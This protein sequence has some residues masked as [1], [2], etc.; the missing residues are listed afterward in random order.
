[1][2]AESA[3]RARFVR[4]WFAIEIGYWRFRWF[5][6]LLKPAYTQASVTDGIAIPLWLSCRCDTDSAFDARAGACAG[7]GFYAHLV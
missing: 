2:G 6:K 3:I 7:G 4:P 1:M 5:V